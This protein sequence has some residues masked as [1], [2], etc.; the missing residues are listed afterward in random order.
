MMTLESSGMTSYERT[1][2]SYVIREALV[3]YEA[4]EY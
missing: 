4:W 1:L 2:V 3:S